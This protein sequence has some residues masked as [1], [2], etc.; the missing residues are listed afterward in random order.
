MARPEQTPPPYDDPRNWKS[1][2][3]PARLAHPVTNEIDNGEGGEPPVAVLL[4]HWHKEYGKSV[5]GTREQI[6]EMGQHLEAAAEKLQALPAMDPQTPAAVRQ[7]AAGLR[8]HFEEHNNAI[9]F[10]TGKYSPGKPEPLPR[11]HLDR[12]DDASQG[13]V[14]AGLAMLQRLHNVLQDRRTATAND[15]RINSMA[16]AALVVADEL[17]AWADDLDN[18]WPNNESPDRMAGKLRAAIYEP[19]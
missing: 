5:Q 16:H 10:E 6:E 7:L 9:D 15:D 12:L 13:I 11:P 14:A 8:E 1:K 4:G 17:D 19:V 2:P 3:A 18:S